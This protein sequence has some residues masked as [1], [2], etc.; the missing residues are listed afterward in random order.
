M[1]VV[2][3]I[4]FLC[5]CQVSSSGNGDGHF[6]HANIIMRLVLT[7]FQELQAMMV[8]IIAI[9]FDGEVTFFIP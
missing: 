7:L 3:Y 2:F 9:M 8:Y 5:H 6:L 1:G 4:I